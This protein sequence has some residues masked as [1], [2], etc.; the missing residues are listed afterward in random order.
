[1]I[2]YKIG[3]TMSYWLKSQWFLPSNKVKG[4]KISFKL[5]YNCKRDVVNYLSCGQPLINPQHVSQFQIH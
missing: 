2:V 3:D 4:F 5:P 1:M